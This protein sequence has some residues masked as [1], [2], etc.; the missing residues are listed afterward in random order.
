MLLPAAAWGEKDGT[1]T[2]SERRISRQRPFL[3]LPG[4][5]RPDW[6]IVTRGRAA[7]GL[8]GGIRLRGPPPTCSASTRRCRHSRTTASAISISARSRRTA[9]AAVRRARSGEVACAR[10][11]AHVRDALLRRRRIFHPRSPGALRRAGAAAAD[12]RAIDE[13]SVAAEHR[14]LARPMAHHDP[15]RHRV[16]G[17][18][19]IR[20]SLSSRSIRPMRAAEARRRRVCTSHDAVR[21]VRAEGRQSPTA[22]GAARSLRRSIGATPRRRMRPHRRHWSRRRTIRIPASPNSKATPARDRAGRVR[23]L[24]ALR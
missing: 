23:H 21:R 15:H 22:S 7:F 13:L 18:A 2:N 6:W 11:R 5:A 14:A 19:P 9:D 12:A 8:C 3:P 1:V 17:F 10:R 16:R 20:P 24:A 4:E